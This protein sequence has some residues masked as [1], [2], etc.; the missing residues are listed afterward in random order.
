MVGDSE[1]ILSTSDVSFLD[2][3]SRLKEL[4]SDLASLMRQEFRLCQCLSILEG[5]Q[6]ADVPCLSDLDVPRPRRCHIARERGTPYPCLSQHLQMACHS[7]GPPWE[8]NRESWVGEGSEAC[9]LRLIPIEDISV[10]PPLAKSS[11]DGK[12]YQEAPVVKEEDEGVGITDVSE[13][14]WDLAGSK[15]ISWCD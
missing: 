14:E 1:V 15:R 3:E 5:C 10:E 8:E 6:P 4:E 9:P 11:S 2:H 12:E 13:G 7:S